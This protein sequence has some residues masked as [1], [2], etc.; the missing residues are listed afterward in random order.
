[1]K[2]DSRASDRRVETRDTLMT[3]DFTKPWFGER[4]VQKPATTKSNS[5]YHSTR[6]DV[7]AFHYKSC[8][9]IFRLQVLAFQ[10]IMVAI[11]LISV[12]DTRLYGRS[13]SPPYELAHPMIRPRSVGRSNLMSEG[14]WSKS[15]CF[16]DIQSLDG[17]YRCKCIQTAGNI[18]CFLK[19]PIHIRCNDCNSGKM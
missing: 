10:D 14:L 3:V 17:E 19:C 16:R 15:M 7:S 8:L 18:Q 12:H 4:P 1:M 9:S 5:K 13:F 6:G 2:H 11:L